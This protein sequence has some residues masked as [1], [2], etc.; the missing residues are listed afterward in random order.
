MIT[1]Q[2]LQAFC[3]RNER[4]KDNNGRIQN[5]IRHTAG[6]KL[7]LFTAAVKLWPR[8]HAVVSPTPYA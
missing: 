4:I 1:H 6:S 3:L 5:S 8:L 7:K 2:S